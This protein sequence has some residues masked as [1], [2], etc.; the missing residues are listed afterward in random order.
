MTCPKCSGYIATSSPRRMV[1]WNAPKNPWSC[2]ELTRGVPWHMAPID[3]MLLSSDLSWFIQIY[4]LI[5]RSSWDI[6]IQHGSH[7]CLRCQADGASSKAWEPSGGWGVD[8][9]MAR[10]KD[11]VWQEGGLVHKS[12]FAR[13]KT[14][15][16]EPYLNSGTF[17]ELNWMQSCRTYCWGKWLTTRGSGLRSPVRKGETQYMVR[18]KLHAFWMTNSFFA[19]RMVTS[20]P[21]KGASNWRIH[22]CMIIYMDGSYNNIPLGYTICYRS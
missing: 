5:Y 17:A 6:F 1:P 2:I 18:R 9:K 7:Y 19:W 11:Q 12:L 15:D 8:Q 4:K 3:Y 22:S 10:E 21:N 14:L 20:W 13:D 16:Q